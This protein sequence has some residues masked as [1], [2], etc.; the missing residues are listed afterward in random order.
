MEVPVVEDYKAICSGM[1][2]C[3]VVSNDMWPQDWNGIND[4]MRKAR[5][6]FVPDGQDRRSKTV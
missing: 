5:A 4:E 6:G 3:S 1:A 2:E